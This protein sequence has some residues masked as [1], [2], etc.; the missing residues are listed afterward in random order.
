MV[1]RRLDSGDHVGDFAAFADRRRFGTQI[2][3]YPDRGIEG[4]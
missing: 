1:L 2:P 3:R 4:M